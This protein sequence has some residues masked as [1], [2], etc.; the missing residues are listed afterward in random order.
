[1]CMPGTAP[2]NARLHIDGGMQCQSD[3]PKTQNLSAPAACCCEP[4]YRGCTAEAI[5]TLQR[6]QAL[7]YYS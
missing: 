1:M 5:V 4:A 6:F 2:T 3:T 7:M